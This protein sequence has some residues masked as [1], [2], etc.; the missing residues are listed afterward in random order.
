MTHFAHRALFFG[1][2]AGTLSL[3]QLTSVGPGMI[4]IDKN[5][6]TL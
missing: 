3:V 2:L 4:F 1:G 5:N 6:K